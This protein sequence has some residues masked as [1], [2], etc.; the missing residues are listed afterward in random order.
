MCRDAELE[1]VLHE[2]DDVLHAATAHGGADLIEHRYDALGRELRFADRALLVCGEVRL[3][4]VEDGG[5][6]FLL[7]REVGQPDFVAHRVLEGDLH[8]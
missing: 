8:G 3:Q 1:T 2:R 7:G 6:P 5:E 4:S